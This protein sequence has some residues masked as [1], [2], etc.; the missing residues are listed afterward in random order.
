MAE[1]RARTAFV[2]LFCALALAAGTASAAPGQRQTQ[3][4]GHEAGSVRLARNDDKAQD[5]ER[6]GGT[7]GPQQR[8]RDEPRGRD[9]RGGRDSAEGAQRRAADNGPRQRVERERSGQPVQARRWEE[10]SPGERQRLQRREQG[11]RALPGEQQQRL[12]QA[13]ERYRSMSPDQR[14][15][16]R[17]RWE[18]MSES[19]RERYRRRIEKRDD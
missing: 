4:R 1:R 11:F 3:A 10:L 6:G 15:E 2:M 7:T 19:D 13:E 17:R 18:G 5:R 14:E 16:L 12:R 9:G 8:A